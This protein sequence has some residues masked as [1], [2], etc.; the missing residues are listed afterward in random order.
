MK[1]KINLIIF[2]LI[3]LLVLG[4]INAKEVILQEGNPLKMA[5]AITKLVICREAIAKISTEPD[6]YIMRNKDG[7][8]PFLKQKAKAGWTFV[9]QSGAGLVLAKNGVKHIFV[10]RMFTRYFRIVV[11]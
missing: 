6:K 5:I 1:N 9:E 7:F 10:G 11:E 4:M 2:L 3:L 8:E